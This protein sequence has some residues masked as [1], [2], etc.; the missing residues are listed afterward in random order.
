MLRRIGRG[1]VG[2]RCDGWEGGKA[3]A[4]DVDV[5][6][7]VVRTGAICSEL[8]VEP[9]QYFFSSHLLFI[10]DMRQKYQSP[11]SIH[12]HHHHHR[13]SAFTTPY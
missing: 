10:V 3:K 5:D 8:F 13:R 4:V 6:V 12:A 11:S 7:G 9:D 2:G 1:L